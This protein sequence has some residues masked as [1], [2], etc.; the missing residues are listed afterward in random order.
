MRF[1]RV[2]GLAI[3]GFLHVEGEGERMVSEVRCQESEKN[4]QAEAWTP[5]AEVLVNGESVAGSRRY[6]LQAEAWT[7]TR[8]NGVKKR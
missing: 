3:A 2:A 6:G 5:T 8:E 7:V 4:R 1:A